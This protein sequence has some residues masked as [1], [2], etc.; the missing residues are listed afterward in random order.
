MPTDNA[1]KVFKRRWR[2]C[3]IK[4][5]CGIKIVSVCAEST[6]FKRIGRMRGK[7]LCVNGEDAKSILAYSPVTPRDVK[8]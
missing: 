6:V 1:W 4:V 2:L 3:Q 7:D 5:I 8:V